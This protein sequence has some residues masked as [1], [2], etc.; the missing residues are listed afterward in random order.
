MTATASRPASAAAA[1]SGSRRRPASTTVNPAPAS[2]T[3]EARPMPLPAPVTSAIALTSPLDPAAE[4]VLDVDAD[5]LLE[6]RLRPEPE[7]LRAARVEAARPARDDPHRSS[8][9]A[10]AGCSRTTSSPAT[11]RSASICSPTVTDTPASSGSAGRRARCSSIAAAWRRKPTAAR[12]DAMPVAHVVGDRQHRLLAV[13][14]AR[15]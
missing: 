7:R 5:D 8:R 1:S 3:A 14:A 9:R 10:R 11:R 6:A 12:G 13:R 4:L 2:A 15:G